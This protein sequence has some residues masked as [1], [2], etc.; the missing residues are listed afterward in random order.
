M[1]ILSWGG[2]MVT[3]VLFTHMD[4]PGHETNSNSCLPARPNDNFIT[5]SKSKLSS[6]IIHWHHH[7]MHSQYVVTNTNQEKMGQDQG[8]P[9]PAQPSRG[10]HKE[11][12]VSSLSSLRTSPSSGAPPSLSRMTIQRP[13]A[14]LGRMQMA[15]MFHTSV[16][17]ATVN[18]PAPIKVS[19]L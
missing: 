15:I 19:Q 12:T 16:P 6:A 2:L 10:L 17:G 4:F 14:Q 5:R 1:G 3:L 18:L 11:L 9:Q 7:Q 8:Q 13:G